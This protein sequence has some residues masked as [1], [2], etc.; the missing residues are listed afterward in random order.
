M[1][2][3]YE[4][5]NDKLRQIVNMDWGMSGDDEMELLNPIPARVFSSAIASPALDSAAVSP[6]TGASQSEAPSGNAS[7]LAS[8]RSGE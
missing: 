3:T 2:S 7:A 8:P 5:M 1:Y 6:R 4:I